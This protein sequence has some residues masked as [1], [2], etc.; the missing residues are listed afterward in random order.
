MSLSQMTLDRFRFHKKGK[1]GQDE[2][3]GSDKRP[4]TPENT[5]DMDCIPETPQS[6]QPSPASPVVIAAKKKKK[7]GHALQ[8]SDSD[9]EGSPKPV[10]N[11][12]ILKGRKINKK[13]NNAAVVISDESSDDDDEEDEDE[14][15]GT[16]QPVAGRPS[17]STSGYCSNGEGR[18]VARDTEDKVAHLQEIFPEQSREELLEVILD[19]SCLESAV[20]AAFK[21]FS[22]DDE[23]THAPTRRKRQRVE[24]QESNDSVESDRPSKKQ[25]TPFKK[26]EGNAEGSGCGKKTSVSAKLRKFRFDVPVDLTEESTSSSSQEPPDLLPMKEEKAESPGTPIV[27]HRSKLRKLRVAV[28]DESDEEEDQKTGENSKPTN[29]KLT[30]LSR[31]SSPNSVLRCIRV[32]NGP[33]PGVSTA[34]V[35]PRKQ[36]ARKSTNSRSEE[37]PRGTSNRTASLLGLNEDV[38]Q[39]GETQDSD[40]TVINSQGREMLVEQLQEFFPD[41]PREDI[42]AALEAE[43]WD[44]EAAASSLSIRMEKDQEEPGERSSRRKQKLNPRKEPPAETVAGTSKQK[45]KPKPSKKKPKY[46]D[47]DDDDDGGDAY[48]SDDDLDDSYGEDEEDEDDMP[49]EKQV[50]LLSLFSDATLEEL[51]TV[52]GCSKK[53][54][55]V[56]MA[57]R[58]FK[59]WKD[60]VE[61]FSTTTGLSCTILWSG[62]VL[63]KERQVIK[64]LMDQCH[65]I[66]KAHQKI[67]TS[68]MGRSLEHEDD[69]GDMQLT[70]QPGNMSQSLQLKPYQLVGLNWLAL[71]HS[72][73]IN[74]ILAD[75]MGLGKTAQAIS[76]L[77]Y[78]LEQGDDGPHVIIV[79]SSTIDNWVRELAVWCPDLKVLIYY[80]NQMDRQAMR[81]DILEGVEEFHVL[82]TTYQCCV[83]TATD[84]TLFRKVGFNYAILD[85]GHM[86]KNMQTQRY[87]QLLRIRSERRLLLT[88]TPIQNNLLELM[89]LLNFIMPDMFS[90]RTTELRRMFAAAPKGKSESKFQRERIRHAKRIMQPF[91]LRRLKRD[92]L[93]QLPKK[94]EQVERCPMTDK[95]V[96][97]YSD[98]KARLS[99]SLKTEDGSSTLSGAMMQLRKMA[100]HPLL[101][102]TYY[103]LDMLRDMSKL[104]LKEPTHHDAS[105]DLIFEDME[106][107]SD[108]ELNNLC[109]MY[110]SLNEYT[111]SP[112]LLLDSGK[113]RL[114]DRLL[115]EMAERGDRVLLFSQLTMMLDIVEPYLKRRKYKYVRL[116]GQTPVPER[117]QLIDKYNNNPDIFIFLLSTRAGGLGINL[118]SANTVILHDIDFNPYNDKQAEDRCHRVGQTKDVQVMR[119]VS[120]GTVEEAILQCAEHKLQLEQDMTSTEDENAE[121][122]SDMAKLLRQCLDL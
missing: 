19:T 114:L 101:H 98:L 33:T 2:G 83:G 34:S 43:N 79:P 72:Q 86:L 42:V 122:P 82:I 10:K 49:S 67:V 119:L 14:E 68:Q 87:Q 11:G 100:N 97:L 75:E 37:S 15:D 66:S 73:G 36:T 30:T 105:A 61:K 110:A 21:L 48:G 25:C 35:S 69:E 47:S 118:T 8:Y 3:E 18:A 94:H 89:S 52:P 91:V 50:A 22:N 58:P 115:P 88:G 106:V 62:Q 27:K 117:L 38:V 56:I 1:P 59:G 112:D 16:S 95:Q 54:A 60:I 63:L 96:E 90:A 116:D 4:C 44:Q 41:M 85:E 40:V 102:R 28:F 71:L 84:R 55:E 5:I 17:S 93:T 99:R 103:T 46:A 74:G 32:D 24:S 39:N 92:V 23:T 20:A 81:D 45:K 29:D 31:P 7:H 65:K 12:N 104:M 108:F 80:G 9:G 51:M 78:L 77:A 76:F 13:R 107:M 64:R 121:I 26:T 57:A 120:A 113:F 111:L 109:K 53:K 6:Q 70:E